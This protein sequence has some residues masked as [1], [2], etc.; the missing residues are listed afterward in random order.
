[1]KIRKV[2]HALP[3]QMKADTDRRII[4]G[5][6]SVFDVLDSYGDVVRRGAFSE[7]IEERFRKV[8]RIKMLWQHRPD[9]PIGL[10]V[11]MK[12]DRKGLWV[13]GKVSE[14]RLGDESLRLISDGVVDSTTSMGE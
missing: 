4:S 13:S 2:K 14:T 9:L 8:P 3:L 11:D 1:M 12:E 5:Y 7:T 6:A 10:P